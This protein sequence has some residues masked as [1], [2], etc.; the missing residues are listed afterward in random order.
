VCH[1]GVHAAHRRIACTR[2]FCS[3]HARRALALRRCVRRR[4]GASFCETEW[5]RAVLRNGGRVSQPPVGR[6]PCFL[7]GVHRRLTRWDGVWG[8]ATNAPS[9]KQPVLAQ[10]IHGRMAGMTARHAQ[11]CEE[12]SQH[13]VLD[14]HPISGAAS[15]RGRTRQLN[16]WMG[17]PSCRLSCRGRS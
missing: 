5:A 8:A 2:P 12:M 15:G 16:R 9:S 3:P 10:A 7:L 17:G 6:G 1:A 11:L 13:A 14:P 4:D